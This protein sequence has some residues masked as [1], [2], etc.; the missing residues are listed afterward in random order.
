MILRRISA[1]VAAIILLLSMFGLGGCGGKIPHKVVP[2]YEKRGVRLIAVL[3]V[4]NKK[5]DPDMGKLFRERLIDGL[6]FKGYPKIPAA[7]I[8]EKIAAFYKNVRE[9]SKETMPPRDLGALLGV[10]ALLYTELL[11]CSTS[12]FY[13]YASLSVAAQMELVSTRTGETLWETRYGTTERNFEIT[14]DRLK[15]K[16][17]QVYEPAMQGIIDRAMETIPDGPDI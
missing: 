3:P 8:D 5:G 6:Y 12:F 13:L 1:L 15:M 10:D 17:C 7:V 9:V 4:M 14:P 2:E 11:D 16:A